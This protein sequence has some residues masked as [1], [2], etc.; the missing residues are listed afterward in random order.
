MITSA[1]S[2]FSLRINVLIVTITVFVPA[3][4]GGYP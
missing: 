2:H 1:F 4:L 3:M